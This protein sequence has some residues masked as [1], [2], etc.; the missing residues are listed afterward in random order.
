MLLF[1]IRKSEVYK[2]TNRSFFFNRKREKYQ[3]SSRTLKRWL[4]FENVGRFQ[5]QYII[6][7]RLKMDDDS[8]DKTVTSTSL[9]SGSSVVVIS[10]PYL[11]K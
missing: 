5:R 3:C 10:Y 11:R 1:L 8:E 2:I 9:T 7:V 4:N 6:L